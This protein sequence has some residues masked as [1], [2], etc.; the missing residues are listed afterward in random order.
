MCHDS[1]YDLRVILSLPQRAKKRAT[2]N[3]Q[4][5]ARDRSAEHRHRHDL[6]CHHC[7]RHGPRTWSYR[8]RVSFEKLV[9]E[10]KRLGVHWRK[11]IRR[12]SVSWRPLFLW[13]SHCRKSVV[14]RESW[15]SSFFGIFSTNNVIRVTFSRFLTEWRVMIWKI[16]NLRKLVSQ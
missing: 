16:D 3:Y 10:W 12:R 2:G 13:V 8:R 4:Q 5:S 6:P 14:T 7:C 1:S 9:R 11:W 15:P